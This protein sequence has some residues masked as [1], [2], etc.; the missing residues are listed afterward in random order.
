M[1]RRRPTDRASDYRRY[2]NKKKAEL[3]GL[4]D[5][6]SDEHQHEE[7]LLI[8]LTMGS[9]REQLREQL[10]HEGVDDGDDEVLVE[11]L[12]AEQVERLLDVVLHAEPVVGG[13][14]DGAGG[15]G[16]RGDDAAGAFVLD[17]Q[18]FGG[19]G[20][21]VRGRERVLGKEGGASGL[22]QGGQEGRVQQ[23]GVEVIREQSMGAAKKVH[24]VVSE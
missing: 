3:A 19:R 1:F 5:G 16:Q 18:G 2:V 22:Q 23:L 10:G 4:C 7:T 8:W 20:R 21:R 6:E 9:T 17:S 24:G 13:E 12:V 15:R 14:E 11:V